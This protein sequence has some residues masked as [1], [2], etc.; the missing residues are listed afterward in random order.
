MFTLT[1]HEHV[2]GYSVIAYDTNKKIIDAIYEEQVDVLRELNHYFESA[3]L[4]ELQRRKNHAST[5]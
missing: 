5:M 2:N 3:L 1:I 4:F